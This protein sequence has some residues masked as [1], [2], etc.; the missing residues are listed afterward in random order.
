[1][2]RVVHPAYPDDEITHSLLLVQHLRLMLECYGIE[3]LLGAIGCVLD[4]R[5]DLGECYTPASPWVH[6]IVTAID[7]QA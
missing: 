7:N 1:M 4:V 2:M 6:D 5:P 3:D